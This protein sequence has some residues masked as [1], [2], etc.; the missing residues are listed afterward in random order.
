MEKIGRW[1]GNLRSFALTLYHRDL[2]GRVHRFAADFLPRLETLV[3]DGD[4]SLHLIESLLVS[5]KPISLTIY[6]HQAWT[7][8]MAG[9]FFGGGGR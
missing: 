2:F 9:F 5:T 4:V 1:C 3:I 8:K 6:I 7:F